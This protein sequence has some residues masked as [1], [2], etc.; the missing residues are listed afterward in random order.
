MNECRCASSIYILSKYALLPISPIPRG[1]CAYRCL[2]CKMAV[3]IDVRS[4]LQYWENIFPSTIY[5]RRCFSLIWCYDDGLYVLY[6]AKMRQFVAKINSSVL[7]RSFSLSY[8]ISYYQTT[9]Y[10]LRG[11]S[12]SGGRIIMVQLRIIMTHNL[13]NWIIRIVT[14][15]GLYSRLYLDNSNASICQSIHFTRIQIWRV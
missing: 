5:R 11:S 4:L 13:I 12:E 3:I 10:T 9:R 14:K 2:R 7:Y 15:T 6:G 1:R 8:A